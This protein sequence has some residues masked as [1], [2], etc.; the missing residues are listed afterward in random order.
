M[1]KT[2]KFIVAAVL[3]ATILVCGTA[4]VV[5]AQGDERQGRDEDEPWPPPEIRAAEQNRQ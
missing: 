4:A 3:V 2:R 5:L 1:W